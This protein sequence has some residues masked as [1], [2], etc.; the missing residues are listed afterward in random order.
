MSSGLPTDYAARHRRN[1]STGIEFPCNETNSAYAGWG[2]AAK[3]ALVFQPGILFPGWQNWA[4][5]VSSSGNKIL[6]VSST[7]I[8]R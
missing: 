2:Y 8:H 7:D 4:P 1:R 5:F 6:I 3:A